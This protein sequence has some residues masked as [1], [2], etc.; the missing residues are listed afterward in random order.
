MT[1]LMG[2]ITA[3]CVPEPPTSAAVSAIPPTWARAKTILTA[4]TAL[5]Q[6]EQVSF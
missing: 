5:R 3:S 6:A 2:A 1:D 4:A